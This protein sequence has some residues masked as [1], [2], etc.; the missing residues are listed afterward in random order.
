MIS[1]ELLRRGVKAKK[2]EPEQ[3]RTRAIERLL[4]LSPEALEYVLKPIEWAYNW[5]DQNEP[6]S[7]TNE[8][9]TRFSLVRCALHDNSDHVFRVYKWHLALFHTEIEKRR[10]PNNDA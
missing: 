4:N 6:E 9:S 1:P 2:Q 7:M 8:G 5:T 10:R 3:A